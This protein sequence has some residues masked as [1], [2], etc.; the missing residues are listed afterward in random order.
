MAE[1]GEVVE[2]V[3]IATK[4]QRSYMGGGGLRAIHARPFGRVPIQI[5]EYVAVVMYTCTL[6]GRRCGAP[7]AC[8]M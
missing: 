6:V 8:N 3:R 7:A 2:D 5:A 4:L 1:G